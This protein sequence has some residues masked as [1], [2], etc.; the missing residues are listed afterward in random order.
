MKCNL[1]MTSS[2]VILLPYTCPD[3][4]SNKLFFL[5]TPT[6]CYIWQPNLFLPG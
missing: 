6:P 5:S 4:F 3:N 1:L 2:N